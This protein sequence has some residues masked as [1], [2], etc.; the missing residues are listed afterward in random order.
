MRSAF[1]LKEDVIWKHSH[2]KSQKEYDQFANTF[3]GLI[4]K[5]RSDTVSKLDGKFTFIGYGWWHGL[6]DPKR[7]SR[8]MPQNKVLQ[9][10]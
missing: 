4:E 1:K 2:C 8:K 10:R 3:N 5:A 6:K 9:S 7:N